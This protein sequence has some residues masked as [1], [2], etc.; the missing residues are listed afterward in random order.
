MWGD[1]QEHR[2]GIWRKSLLD[3][4]QETVVVKTPCGVCNGGHACLTF[5]TWYDMEINDCQLVS[6][7]KSNMHLREITI[8]AA[9]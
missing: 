5:Y 7:V 8:M 4:L 1:A 2:A 3:F 6:A 9:I